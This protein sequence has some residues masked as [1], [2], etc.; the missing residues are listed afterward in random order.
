MV[1]SAGKVKVQSQQ[2]SCYAHPRTAHYD[3]YQH[4]FYN[5]KKL[6]IANCSKIES[7]SDQKPSASLMHSTLSDCILAE[8]N[9]KCAARTQS[10]YAHTHIHTHTHTHTV[11]YCTVLYCTVLAP[12]P[13]GSRGLLFFQ[14]G[15]A[16]QNG[17]T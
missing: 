16:R 13:L 10:T 12:L 8:R 7:K 15:N 1:C 2:H 9:G 14:G 17:Q 4:N 5:A 6:E 3:D 11:L